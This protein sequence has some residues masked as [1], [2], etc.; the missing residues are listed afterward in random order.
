METE[1]NQMLTLDSRK[2]LTL[3]LVENVESFSDE[4]VVLKTALG[5]MTIKG[6]SL[7]IEDLSVQNGNIVVS[8]KIDKMDFVEIKEKHSFFQRLFR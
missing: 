7:K 5:G 2:R 8:G 6:S 3:T 1:K 4:E